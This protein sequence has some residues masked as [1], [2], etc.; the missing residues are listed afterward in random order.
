MITD[1]STTQPYQLKVDL[2]QAYAKTQRLVST[3]FRVFKPTCDPAHPDWYETTVQ[4]F[5]ARTPTNDSSSGIPAAAASPSFLESDDLLE[6]AY[7]NVYCQLC[8][9]ISALG[10]YVHS[11]SLVV[12]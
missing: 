7:K 9:Y 1:D 3:Q 4:R 2:L 5:A 11:G 8:D 6:D 10:E 12:F